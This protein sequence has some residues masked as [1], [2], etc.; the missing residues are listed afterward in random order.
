MAGYGTSYNVYHKFVF[1]RYTYIYESKKLTF[2]FTVRFAWCSDNK[3]D[4]IND[5]NND[6][7]SDNGKANRRG[8]KAATLSTPVLP[9]ARKII[10]NLN[11]DSLKDKRF[12]DDLAEFFIYLK[13]FGSHWPTIADVKWIY[14]SE[15]RE[16]TE[17][18]KY[19]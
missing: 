4:N 5:H 14:Q 15:L 2:S 19:K 6:N 12:P 16:M 1:R 10:F 18:V 17:N 9:T 8:P 11:K 7:K 13:I 3:N